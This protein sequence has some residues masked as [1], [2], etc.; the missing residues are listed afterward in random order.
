MSKIS[1]SANFEITNCRDLYE[2]A[3]YDF[4][5]LNKKLN[6]YDL[7][8]FLCTISHLHDWAKHAPELI[9][10]EIP[11][12]TGGSLGIVRQLCN[13]AK[14]F[15]KR[16]S[17]PDTTVKMGY[18]MGRYGVALYGSGEKSYIVNIEG[19]ELPVLAICSDAMKIWENFINKHYLPN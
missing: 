7:F 12:N 15:E 17:H 10:I 6:S 19:K 4:S 13:R 9:G 18:G 11:D 1:N 2:K 16:Q 8:N 5:K 14:H 3:K